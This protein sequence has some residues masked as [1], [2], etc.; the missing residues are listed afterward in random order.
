M[1]G[2]NELAKHVLKQICCQEWVHERCLRYPEVLC[3]EEVIRDAVLSHQQVCLL[4]KL[5][6]FH[7]IT[8]LIFF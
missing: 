7:C 5:R 4:L 6:N 8:I 2:L 3:S 1:I